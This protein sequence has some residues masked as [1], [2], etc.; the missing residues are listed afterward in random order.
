MS[1]DGVPLGGGRTRWALTPEA[2]ERLLS[3]LDP[4]RERAAAAYEQ[5]RYRLV[6]LLRWWG[7]MQAEDLA[8]DTLDRVAKKLVEG[9]TIGS[10]SL[11]AYVRGVA[12]MVYYESTREPLTPLTDQEPAAA[13]NT[14]EPE[15][16]SNCLDR[17]LASLTAGERSLLLKYY[18]GGKAADARR[19][20]AE[21]LGIS[22]TALRIRA[23]RLRM[24][25]ERCVTACLKVQ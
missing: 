23:H 3:A 20:L 25:V 17:C 12:R 22:M 16:A 6:G 24:T 5:L 13:V 19:R 11:G 2:F 8:D 10:G 1:N 14:G 21:E 18:D 7:A 4:D 9:A 15:Q